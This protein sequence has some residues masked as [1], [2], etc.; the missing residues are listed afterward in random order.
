M[1]FEFRETE[2]DGVIEI[3][4]RVFNDDRG[5]FLE[6]YKKSDFNSA[7]IIED[8]IQDNH[9][10]SSKGTLRGMHLQKSPF[11]QGK[12]VSVVEGKV[13]DLAIDLRKGSDTFSKWVG[14]ELDG[15]KNNMLYIPPGFAH[16]FIVLSEN[17]HFLYKCTAEYNPE[18]EAGIRWDDP[19]IGVKWPLSE[20]LVSERDSKLPYLKDLF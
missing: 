7:G 5:Y 6:T 12:L 4:P 1:P 19:D 20:P 18:A 14:V 2:L 8:F 13:L 16:A 9:S 17:A 15:K 10:Y 11:A 3:Y